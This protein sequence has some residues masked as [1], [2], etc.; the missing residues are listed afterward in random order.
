MARKPA[1]SDGR[2][3]C[4]LAAAATLTNISHGVFQM[5]KDLVLLLTVEA[6]CA[7]P[8]H[9]WG[10]Q[11]AFACSTCNWLHHLMLLQ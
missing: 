4:A 1:Y 6:H 7:F 9:L 5:W 3:W 2:L 10:L 8:S 11:P